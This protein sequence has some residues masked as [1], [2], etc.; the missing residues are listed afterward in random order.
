MPESVFEELRRLAKEAGTNLS[1]I[2]T[3]AGHHKSTVW[4]WKDNPPQQIAMHREL[5]AEIDRAK[6]QK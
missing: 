3:R 6:S 2:C 4:G 1:T 5:L